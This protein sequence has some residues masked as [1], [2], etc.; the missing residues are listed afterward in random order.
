MAVGHGDAGESQAP[1]P[2]NIPCTL[3]RHCVPVMDR[4]PHLPP[5]HLLCWGVGHVLASFWV[6]EALKCLWLCSEGLPDWTVVRPEGLRIGQS[7]TALDPNPPFI[8][9]SPELSQALDVL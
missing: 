4:P 1:L 2:G 3:C 5:R 8:P 7:G 9:L 6:G